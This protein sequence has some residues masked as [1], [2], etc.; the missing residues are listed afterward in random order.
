M[1]AS[2]LSPYVRYACDSYVHYPYALTDR[3][4]FDYELL[5]VKEGEI[6]LTLVGGGGTPL[7][8]NP[9]TF[10]SFAPENGTASTF[11]RPMSGSRTSILTC[12]IRRT[13][14]KCR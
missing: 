9:A 4:I 7:Q 12:F 11:T 5:Y 13:A 2:Y 8:A 3:I 14:R 10:F 1:K 6:T